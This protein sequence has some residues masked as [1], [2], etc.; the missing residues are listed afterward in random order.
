M[1]V[2]PSVC[3]HVSARLALIG[4]SWDFILEASTKICRENPNLATI[5][6]KYREI[7]MTNYARL[8]CW[9]Q[10]WIFVSRQQ[11]NSTSTMNTLLAATC[12]STTIQ[13]ELLLRFS[14]NA[15]V[16]QCYVI[17]TLLISFNIVSVRWH[18]LMSAHSRKR[19]TS[20]KS[21]T[22]SFDVL[23]SCKWRL[24]SWTFSFC[25]RRSFSEVS[26]PQQ[27]SIATRDT[28]FPMNKCQRN[29][30]W[31]TTTESLF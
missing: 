18:P 22:Q 10:Y 14:A 13:R 2:R 28:V 16:M 7:Y 12:T 1:F 25:G 26:H 27:Y 31:V 24:S 15:N 3:P 23:R 11:R 29:I 5:G 19:R 21:L 9:Q 20:D 8:K 6:Q 4:F 17:R 30:R